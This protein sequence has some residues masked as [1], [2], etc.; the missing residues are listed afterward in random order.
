MAKAFV[1]R[2]EDI[3]EAVLYAVCLPETVHV[4]EIM[5]RPSQPLQIPGM[6]LPA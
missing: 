6:R 4:N 3:A 5:I 2:P 1:L